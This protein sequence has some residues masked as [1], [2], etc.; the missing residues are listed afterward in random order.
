MKRLFENIFRKTASQEKCDASFEKM[1]AQYRLPKRFYHTFSGHITFCLAEMEKVPMHMLKDKDAITI[2]LFIHDVM[3]DFSSDENEK[4][5]AQFGLAL[6][7]E[8]GAPEKFGSKVAKLVMAT[9]HGAI[10][11]SSDERIVIDIDLAIL[12]QNA[13]IFEEYEKNIRLEYSFVPE[14]LFKKKR[15]EILQQF[16]DRPSIFLTRHFQEKYE[17]RARANLAGSIKQLKN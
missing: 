6:C 12:G 15:A 3:M 16:L 4:R 2:A 5:S 9:R 7:Q 14:G 17:E 8:L 11:K 13:K 1:V 10:P